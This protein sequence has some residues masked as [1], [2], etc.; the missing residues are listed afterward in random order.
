[1]SQRATSFSTLTT[2]ATSSHPGAPARVTSSILLTASDDLARQRAILKE[3]LVLGLRILHKHGFEYHVS[4]RI[5]V[6]DPGDP[7]TFW[8]HPIGLAFKLVT[9][10]DLM[11]VD[12][13]GNYLGGGG[14]RCR[15]INVTACKVDY[16]VFTARPDITTI[17][18]IHSTHG[19]AFSALGRHLDMLTQESAVFF[20]EHNLYA[21]SGELV[22]KSQ[23]GREVAEALGKGKAVIQHNHGLMTV[24]TTID[25]ALAWAIVLDKECQVQLLTLSTGLST[26]KIPPEDAALLRSLGGTEEDGV[27]KAAIYFQ[28]AEAEYFSESYRKGY[29]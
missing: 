23:E 29:P 21:G 2:G 25:S 12:R 19:M 28:E 17:C 3:R 13:D 11:L 4:P 26:V 22:S 8:V 15:K 20:E 18:H 14:D 27:R 6:R 7:N 24:G 16:P 9:S 5:T 1:M 10:T